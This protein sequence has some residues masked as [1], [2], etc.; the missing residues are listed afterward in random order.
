MRTLQLPQQV[1]QPFD[2]FD[3][4][5]ALGAG[6]IALGERTAHQTAQRIDVIGKGFGQLAHARI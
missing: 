1:T 2:L 4:M 3:G 6:R 5:I